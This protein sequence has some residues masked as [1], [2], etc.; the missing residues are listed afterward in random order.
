[1]SRK[2]IIVLILAFF[3][4]FFSSCSSDESSDIG[5]ISETIDLEKIKL[6]AF[7]LLGITPVSIEIIDPTIVDN[8]ET[9]YGEINVV[10][11]STN[12]LNKIASLITSDELNLSKFDILPGST[13]SLDYEEQSHVH[14]IVAV[15]DKSKELLHYTVS[16]EKEV[17]PIPSS[18]TITDFKFEASKNAQLTED[19]LI[20]RRFDNANRQE[21]Y[22]FVPKGTDF[23][24]LTPT[25][26]FDA[27]EVFYTQDLTIPIVDIDTPY[28]DEDTNFDFAYPK[29]F[30]LV[31]RDDASNRIKWVNVIVDVKNPVQLESSDIT[32]DNVTTPGVA[33]YFTGI[34]KWKNIGNHKL[35]FQ[36]ATTYE[37]KV[38]DVTTNAINATRK[39][40]AGGLLPGESTNVNIQVAG[41]L[42]VGQYKTTAVFYTGFVG[43]DA[44][45]EL[46]EST[47][48]NITT[49]VVN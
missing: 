3:T 19:A 42:P 9:K 45:D 16:I 7:P 32:T 26:T 5:P 44:I 1:M 29:S 17:L 12:S 2:N 24:N 41:N 15:L 49:N 6:S 37:N 8:K 35:E 13:T 33:E 22:L 27:E 43:L 36:S 47:K 21:I 30:I 10:I 28:P 4:L 40:N 11:P 38:P 23:S 46:I 25:A 18:L 34:T 14:T 48:L 20:V 39:F 31:L